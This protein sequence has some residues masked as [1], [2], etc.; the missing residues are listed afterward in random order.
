[1]R[2]AKSVDLDLKISPLEL[3]T[4]ISRDHENAFLLESC[5]GPERLARFSFIGFSPKKAIVLKGKSLKINGDE[6]E[7]DDPLEILKKE[8]RK[9]PSEA[10]G[11]I[12]GAVGYFSFDYISRIERVKPAEADDLGFPD[13]EFGIFDDAVIYDH[14]KGKAVYSYSG[15]SRLN[16]I[17]GLFEQRVQDTA[18]LKIRSLKCNLSKVEFCRNVETAK[19]SIISGDVFQVV[20]SRRHDIIFSGDLIGFYSKLKKINPSPY[21]YYLKFGERSIVGASPENLIR[22]EG[23]GITSY[24]TLAGTRPRGETPEEDRKLEADLLSDEKERAEHLMLVDLT[25]ND[26]GKVADIGTVMVPE[27]MNVHKYSHVQHIAS[28]VTARLAKGK[29]SFDAFKAIFPAG[30]VSGAPKIRAVEIIRAVERRS[31]GP[32]AG[33]VGY[34]SSNGNADFAI[35]I[36]TLFAKGNRAYIQAGAGIVYDSVPERE[37]DESERK[38]RALLDAMGGE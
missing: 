1:M 34:F 11:F 5:E 15:E 20:L 10:E 4:A 23:R 19:K 25:R 30:T 27:L 2:K 22:V 14:R 3:F 33:A 6:T 38:V 28:L 13:F 8:I 31:R 7:F 21:M 29:D 26:I 12:G 35:A 32:Y 18:P 37:F 9:S 24:A 36:R 16:S 17:M